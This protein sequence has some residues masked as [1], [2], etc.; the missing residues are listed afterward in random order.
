MK[1]RKQV[2]PHIA[3]GQKVHSLFLF[4]RLLLQNH[5]EPGMQAVDRPHL[6]LADQL[7]HQAVLADV[8]QEILVEPGDVLLL[9][10]HEG[11][12]VSLKGGAALARLPGKQPYKLFRALRAGDGLVGKPLLQGTAQVSVYSI[13]IHG[14]LSSPT[15]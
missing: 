11:G 4:V 6:P 2:A 15:V 10:R 1:P 14:Y 8:A 7:L 5:L 13:I 3:D 12:V 9:L